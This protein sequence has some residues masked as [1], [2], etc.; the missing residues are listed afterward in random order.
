[1]RT[2]EEQPI[3][4]D[5]AA[6]RAAVLL[7]LERRLHHT[8]ILEEILGDEAVI[9]ERKEPGAAQIVGAGLADDV[10]H[11][12]DRAAGFDAPPVLQ[13]LELLNRQTL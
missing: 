12:S 10:D 3:P 2:E 13:D 4:Q 8:A 6:H 9:P 7:S 1:V 11:S 5:R